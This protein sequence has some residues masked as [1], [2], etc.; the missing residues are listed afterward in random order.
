MCVTARSLTIHGVVGRTSEAL[1][2]F[3][4]INLVSLN[5]PEVPAGVPELSNW[6]L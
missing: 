6:A 1:G 5:F 3:P 4:L 2:E